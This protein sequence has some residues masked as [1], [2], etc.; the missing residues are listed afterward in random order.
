MKDERISSGS[1][2][3]SFPTDFTRMPPPGIAK[4]DYGGRHTPPEPGRD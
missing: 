3:E 4:R 2:T 1:E